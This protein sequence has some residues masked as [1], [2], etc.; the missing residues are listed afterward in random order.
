MQS[1]KEMNEF[2]NVFG[3]CYKEGYFL[4]LFNIIAEK[5]TDDEKIVFA[6][7]CK[8]TEDEKFKSARSVAVAVSNS[9]LYVSKAERER[10]LI[11]VFPLGK[12]NYVYKETKGKLC[13]AAQN[14]I[15]R[16]YFGNKDVDWIYNGLLKTAD[17]IYEYKK[18]A[19]SEK[20]YYAMKNAKEMNGYVRTNRF[21]FSSLSYL[22]HFEIIEET[23][24]VNEGV[25]AVFG[26]LVEVYSKS[27]ENKSIY[28]SVAFTTK[29]IMTCSKSSMG[30]RVKLTE[31]KEVKKIYQN[32]IDDFR[33]RI[34]VETE[35]GKI[36]FLLHPDVSDKAVQII[37][38][39]LEN[40]YESSDSDCLTFMY[41]AEKMNECVKEKGLCFDKADHID[42]FKEVEKELG[43]SECV[44]LS[45]YADEVSC[46]HFRIKDGVAVAFAA[47][48]IICVHK[49]LF[50]CTVKA[51]DMN[52]E[53]IKN[54]KIER[55]GD[56]A[57]LIYGKEMIE[58]KFK[59]E[60]TDH[61]ILA[62]MEV[63]G[64]YK[65]MPKQNRSEVA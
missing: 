49:K 46:R 6:C 21:M 19:V 51:Y 38:E 35:D 41:K 23:L 30:P 16:L 8:E 39:Y 64:L 43:V 22:E 59:N 52:A 24:Q 29:R 37:E 13:I 50:G 17:N 45:M 27:Q 26:S 10:N 54:M 55:H 63:V 9:T 53:F 42:A 62:L 11:S 32:K 1:A 58:F 44:M 47:S 5:L 4:G 18:A 34:T 65:A 14:K 7:V 2:V 33:S 31:I 36:E 20:R 12:E 60:Q 56:K 48:R 40:D 28:D 61:I 15:I 3:Y 57:C 25:I